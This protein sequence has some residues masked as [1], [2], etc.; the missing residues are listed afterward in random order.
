MLG[1][2]LE[3]CGRPRQHLS[4]PRAP[5]LEVAPC[6]NSDSTRA[7]AVSSESGRRVS[8]AAFDEGLSGTIVGIGSGARSQAVTGIAGMCA[9]GADGLPALA[10]ETVTAPRPQASAMT[11]REASRRATRPGC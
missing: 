3:L 5:A 8:C 11:R 2:E 4:R 1:I 10:L 6:W 9:T 7:T